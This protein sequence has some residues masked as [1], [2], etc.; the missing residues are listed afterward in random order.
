MTI[1]RP[2]VAPIVLLKASGP[3]RIRGI[4]LQILSAAEASPKSAGGIIRRG[5]REAKALHSR[6]R[7]FVADTLF[8]HLRYRGALE[9]AIGSRGSE[10]QLRWLGWLV[11][12]GLPLEELS[13]E[14]RRLLSRCEN[15]EDVLAG[16]AE[17][18]RLQC[19]A[20]IDGRGA[21]L[22][23]ET[24]GEEVW[25]HIEASNGR[26][27]VMLRVNRT[28]TSVDRLMGALSQMG[29]NPQ[30]GRWND[31]AVILETRPDLRRLDKSHA[32]HFELQDE[33]SQLVGSLLAYRQ[34]DKILDYC[35]GAGGKSLQMAATMANGGKG[36]TATDVRPRPLKEL[37]RRAG[38]AGCRKIKTA[39][40]DENGQTQPPLNDQFQTVLV[41]AP[42]T[43]SGVWR[44][45][46]ELRAR[47]TE[48]DDILALQQRVLSRAAA[49]VANGGELIY[50]TCSVL[51]AENESQ[52]E[53]FLREHSDFELVSAS[54]RV[55]EEA[56]VGPYLRVG[57][58]SHGTD[59]F[60]GAILRRQR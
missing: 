6:E 22:L 1:Q 59:G 30:K 23:T 36:L 47:L 13:E 4:G 21:Q 26:A 49:H 35:A 29:L 54:G 43:G 17:E 24:F 60:F 25:A 9:E 10:A 14:D 46:P 12:L 53:R 37:S 33:G 50:A 8:H 20:S 18:Q 15:L 28:K 16:M 19:A 27:P 39:V 34:G 31:N 58:A 40:L 45:H 11:H 55:P 32:G 41:D 2:K 3:G 5:L 42:C 57:P 48:V 51:K 56:V 52:V 44:R 7:R 38:R